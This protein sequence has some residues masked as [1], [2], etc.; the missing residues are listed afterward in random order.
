MASKIDVSELTLNPEEVRDAGQII[1]EK[2]FIN[3]VLS[4][5]HSIETGIEHDKNIVFAGKIVD[6]LIADNGCAPAEGGTLGFT[7]LTW[8][9]KTYSTRYTHCAGDMNNLLK[10]FKKAKRMNPDFYDQVDSE[11]MGLFAARVG[12]MLREVLPKKVWFSDTTAN[13]HTAAGVFTTGT[14]LGLWNVIDGLWKQ[15]FAGISSGDENYVEISKNSGA[16][17]AAQKLA[18]DDAYN[19]FEEMVDAMDERLSEDVDAR[20]YASS[21]MCKNYRK[22]LRNKTLN[23]GFI[24]IAENGKKVLYF[25]NLPIVEMFVWDSTIKASQNNGTIHNL[26]HRALI[27]TPDNIP[28]GTLATEDFEELDSFYDKT[29]KSNIMDVALSLDTKF[30]LPYMA[31]AAY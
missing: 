6:S 26:P 23:A 27:T 29:L 15:I 20:I 3:G 11:A 30:L 8:S 24:E 18:P 17:Y 25:D 12:T 5:N 7:E 16:T 19:V 4:D 2:E 21:S 9:P 14:T 22:T 28:V 10:I 31:V 13:V 1:L